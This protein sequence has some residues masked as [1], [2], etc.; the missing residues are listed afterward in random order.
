GVDKPSPTLTW[1]IPADIVVGTALGST[2]LNATANVPGTFVYSPPAGTVLPVGSAQT[3]AV[4]FTP[5]DTASYSTATRSVPI[6]VVSGAAGGAQ[7]VKIGSL[8][9]GTF[10]DASGH[11]GQSHLVFAPGAGVWWLFTLSSA[12]DSLNDHTVRTYVSSGPN[13]ATATWSAGPPSPPLFNAG[14]A[15]NSLFAGGRS[16]GVA[17]TTIGGVDYAHVFASAAFDGQTS[18]NGHI[19]AKLGAT[20]MTW[21]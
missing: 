1:P 9:A 15:S 4:T 20:T 18:S 2:Q 6:N 21:G 14:G 3:L 8:A 13:L 7:P 5:D 17:L 16:L 12:H 11:S 10:R 19:R